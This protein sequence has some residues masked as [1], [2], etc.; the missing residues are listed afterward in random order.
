MQEF[1]VAE[2]WFI[3]LI[4]AV[5][6]YLL[7]G[8]SGAVFISREVKHEDIREKGSGNPG[9]MNMA[10]TYG[11]K[12]GFFTFMVDLLKGA[13]PTLVGMLVYANYVTASGV[14]AGEIVGYFNGFCVVIGHIYPVFKKF[15]GGKGIATT[16]GVL[17]MGLIYQSL[18][19]LLMLPV[20]YVLLLVWLYFMEYGSVVSLGG[21][22]ALAVIQIVL[23]CVK[24]NWTVSGAIVILCACIL[25][26]CAIDYY[27]HR[28]NIKRL[29]AGE[30]HKTSLKNMLKKKSKK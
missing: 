28:E 25:L 5:L 27:A 14:I 4:M 13:I 7:G 30:E 8:F 10:R 1:L 11:F 12:F 22:S 24:Y 19:F 3:L 20:F 2:Q 6:S 9:T 17:S 18:W 16:F 29:L 21:I 23:Y 26:I 15:K